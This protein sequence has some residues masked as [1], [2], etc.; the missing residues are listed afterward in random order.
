MH[1]QKTSRTVFE[2]IT[3]MT[4]PDPDLMKKAAKCR[5]LAKDVSDARTMALLLEM[6]EEFEANATAMEQT[7]EAASEA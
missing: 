1:C 7:P 6:A 2:C 4:V 3:E 5:R